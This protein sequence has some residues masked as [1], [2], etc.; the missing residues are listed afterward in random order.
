MVFSIDWVVKGF[1]GIQYIYSVNS[2][3]HRA[4]VLVEMALNAPAIAGAVAYPRVAVS[5]ANFA[6]YLMSS[7]SLCAW[8]ERNLK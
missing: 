5:I 2:D 3:A 8:Q 1:G 7:L 4:D 6:K